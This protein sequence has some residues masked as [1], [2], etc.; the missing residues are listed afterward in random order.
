MSQN[1]WL[2][3]CVRVREFSIC[4]SRGLCVCVLG[5]VSQYASVYLTVCLCVRE[6]LGHVS[7]SSMCSMAWGTMCDSV[8]ARGLFVGS[9][10]FPA[11]W[12]MYLEPLRQK[13]EG[14]LRA[15][16]R[17]PPSRAQRG[18]SVGVLGGAFGADG[19][20]WNLF[21]A[22]LCRF[23]PQ[24]R[25]AGSLASFPCHACARKG[26][27]PMHLSTRGSKTLGGIFPA[28]ASLWRAAFP[29]CGDA[30]RLERPCHPHPSSSRLFFLTL[31]TAAGLVTS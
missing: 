18:R 17:Q 20:L 12:L 1:V 19:C 8:S 7:V 10:P 9:F 29:G 15:G 3:L 14:C 27:N 22:R 2:C 25:Q 26:K 4:Q 31:P 24:P 23:P 6:T 21:S 28:S 16:G 5:A 11:L 30:Q 13:K